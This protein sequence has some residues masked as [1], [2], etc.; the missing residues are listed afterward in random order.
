MDLFLLL[1]AMLC[2]LTGLSRPVD[3]RVPA[4]EARRAVAAVTVV[5]NTVIPV[6]VSR[7]DGYVAPAPL[8]LDLGFARRVAPRVTPERRRE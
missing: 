7:P 4:V 2:G 1:T 3:A 5:A 6:A 8:A